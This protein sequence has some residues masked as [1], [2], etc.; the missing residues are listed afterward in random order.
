M[1]PRRTTSSLGNGK[2][3][4]G[5][6][7]NEAFESEAGGVFGG[8]EIEGA[9][10]MAEGDIAGRLEA[11]GQLEAGLDG[12]VAVFA[13]GDKEKAGRGE[14][15]EYVDQKG[16]GVELNDGQGI[17]GGADEGFG[18]GEDLCSGVQASIS[19]GSGPLAPPDWAR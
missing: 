13:G 1:A 7:E 2:G 14:L 9:G 5:F 15:I 17:G 8:A 10:E 4:L 12:E 16:V 18:Q 6:I 11:G 19:A 3:P